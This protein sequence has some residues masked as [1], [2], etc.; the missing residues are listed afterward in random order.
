M[1][2][3]PGCS[4]T[5]AM[6]SGWVACSAKAAKSC[7]SLVRITGQ[8]RC[9]RRA[10]WHG[11]RSLRS[12][13]W[14]FASRAA[15]WAQGSV[16]SRIWQARSSRL[17]LKSRRWSPDK[18]LGQDN[19][20]N[21]GGPQAAAA[22]FEQPGPLGG[23]GADTSGVQDEGHRP[24][25]ARCRPVRGQYGIGPLAGRVQFLLRD[26]PSSASRAARQASSSAILARRS[27]SS[28]SAVAASPVRKACRASLVPVARRAR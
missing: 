25:L 20:R 4:Y 23:Q 2:D 1:K 14:R 12:G 27:I 18:R 28:V 7:G 16:T 17:A 8:G 22:Q 21:L 15:W 11:Q 19:R 10:R 13:R 9:W 26:R 5:G 6:V 3:G 24:L